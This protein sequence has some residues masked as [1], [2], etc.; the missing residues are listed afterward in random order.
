MAICMLLSDKYNFLFIHVY[1]NAG[2]SITHALMPFAANQTQS[3]ANRIIRSF[4]YSYLFGPRPYPDH[5]RASELVEKLGRKKFDSYFSF[6]IARNPWD[7]QVSLYKFMLKNVKHHQHHL[8][9]RLGS[10]EAYV[11]LLCSREITLQ[12]DFLVSGNGE[13][14]VDYV[15]RYENLENDFRQICSRIG[16]SAQLPKKNV[17]N[18]TPYQHYYTTETIEKIE[19]SFR[20]DIEFFDYEFE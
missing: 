5:I 3:L 9:K 16:V 17:S 20:P 8:V 13:L 11:D 1:K 14:L 10:F 6:A 2:T 18:S 15:G 12:K 4:G 19:N 7:W